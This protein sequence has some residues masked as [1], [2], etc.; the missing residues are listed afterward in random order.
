MYKY[1]GYS[2]WEKS[3]QNDIHSSFFVLKPIASANSRKNSPALTEL[4]ISKVFGLKHNGFPG[5]REVKKDAEISYNS[6]S[7]STSK[8]DLKYELL[9]IQ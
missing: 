1:E 7:L 4:T 5:P 9:M 6:L 3:W 2:P 8:S